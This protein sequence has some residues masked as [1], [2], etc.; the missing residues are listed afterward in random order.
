MRSNEHSYDTGSKLIGRFGDPEGSYISY[1]PLVEPLVA[2]AVSS[3]TPEAQQA[4]Y[5]QAL[6]QAHE[7]HW[8]FA[9]W[10]P[11][12]AIRDQRANRRLAPA[13]AAPLA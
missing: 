9:P 2:T 6:R 12:C 8:D 7:G 13:S 4:N 10:L 1:D 5:Y 11:G 3:T